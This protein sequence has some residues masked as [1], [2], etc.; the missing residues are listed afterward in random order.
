MGAEEVVCGDAA[1]VTD[2][3]R[4][5]TGTDGVA[6][7]IETT[8]VAAV[9]RSAYDIMA[10]AGRLVRVTACRGKIAVPAVVSRKDGEASFLDPFQNAL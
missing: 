3:V 9:V 1:A 6:V 10:P 2:Q 5:W 4:D 8:G 7:L